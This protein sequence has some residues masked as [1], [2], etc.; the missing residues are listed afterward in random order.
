MYNYRARKESFQMVRKT[1]PHVDAALASVGQ[2][3]K[4][5]LDASLQMAEK[6]IKVQTEALRDALI[7]A[8]NRALTAEGQVAELE[9]RVA[10]LESQLENHT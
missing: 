9:N 7:E 4:E 1:C 6:S 8:L 5:Q 2:E 10:K 3:I